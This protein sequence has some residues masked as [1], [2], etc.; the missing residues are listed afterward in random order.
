MTSEPKQTGAVGI[1]RAVALFIWIIMVVPLLLCGLL[2]LFRVRPSDFGEFSWVGLLAMIAGLGLIVQSSNRTLGLKAQLSPAQGA[3]IDLQPLKIL[4][5]TMSRSCF[6]LLLVL[7]G[8]LEH[9]NLWIFWMIFAY[10]LATSL[11]ILRTL[12]A[13]NSDTQK[14]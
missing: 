12:W 1:D 8:T 4:A 5:L 14:L 10:L 13:S 11:I 2:A 6:G 9:N 7:V 3:K